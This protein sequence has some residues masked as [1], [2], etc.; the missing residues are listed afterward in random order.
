MDTGSRVH[1]VF[2]GGRSGVGDPGNASRWTRKRPAS[3]W[4]GGGVARRG[5]GHG[6]C[7]SG[8]QGQ[9]LLFHF[10]WRSLPGSDWVAP[11]PEPLASKCEPGVQTA[12]TVSSLKCLPKTLRCRA[13]RFKLPARGGLGEK[14]I[15]GQLDKNDKRTHEE[16][17][18]ACHAWDPCIPARV[19]CG[20][21]SRRHAGKAAVSIG[22]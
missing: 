13:A 11:R 22:Q 12:L 20:D 14:E 8:H 9:L 17:G 16:A 18:P 21:D 19:R 4:E 2:T 10:S 6:K 15:K 7:W 3:F 5:T 1:L